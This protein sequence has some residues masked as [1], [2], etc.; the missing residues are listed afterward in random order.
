VSRPPRNDVLLAFAVLAGVMVE[1]AV[2]LGFGWEDVVKIPGCL[3][4]AW[5]R[6]APVGSALTLFATLGFGELFVAGDSEAYAGLIAMI[7]AMY[8][9]AA[10]ALPAR[11]LPGSLAALGL[12]IANSTVASLHDDSYANA[13]EAISGGVLFAVIVMFAPAYVI[14]RSVRRQGELRAQLAERARELDVERELHAQTAAAQERERMADELHRVVADGLRAMLSELEGARR[15]ALDDPRLAERSVLRVEEHGRDTLTELRSLLG[16]LRRGDE[17]LALA[18]Q[19]SLSR[20]DVLAA[21]AGRG[22]E[23]ALR[24]EGEPRA[25]TPGLD[26]AAYRVV[27]DALAHATGARRAEIVVRWAEHDV[28]LEVSVDGPQLGDAGALAAAR[29][30]VALFGGR[31]DAGRRPRGGSAMRAALPAEVAA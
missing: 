1:Q 24:V 22:I 27:E 31:L 12:L 16:V 26:V 11:V 19:P 10:Y 3:A 9:I 14:G 2:S 20:L 17:D 21:R 5:R 25:L 15:V 13:F 7:V 30:R 23:V 18:P 6:T 28:M 8:S 4:I 29:E